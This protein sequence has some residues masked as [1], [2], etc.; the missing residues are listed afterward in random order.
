MSFTNQNG[1]MFLVEQL[2]SFIWPSNLGKIKT[3]FPRLSYMEAMHMYGTDK[4]D[5]GCSTK[6]I[7]QFI[8]FQLFIFIYFISLYIKIIDS[9]YY[10]F[11]FNLLNIF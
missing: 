7:L 3:P 2:L 9:I 6:V 11:Y 1:V 8:I 10:S 5:I 4:P